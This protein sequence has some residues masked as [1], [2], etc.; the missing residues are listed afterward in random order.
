MRSPWSSHG[1]SGSRMSRCR[2]SC[3]RAPTT[4]TYP[5]TSASTTPARFPAPLS[6]SSSTKAT[7]CS[8]ATPWT[9]SPRWPSALRPA[10]NKQRDSTH[11]WPFPSGLDEDLE[12]GS[13][14]HGAVAVGYLGE[15]DRAVEHPAWLD[16]A[17]EHIGQQFLDVGAGRRDPAGERDVAE[18]HAEV[19]GHVGVLRGADPAD[20][21]A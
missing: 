16:T 19:G 10:D 5:A 12:G 2:P 20:R 4:G 21:A 14:G 17:F 3:G 13:A 11:H 18:E 1:T 15:A 8:T 6:P 9:F 7:S